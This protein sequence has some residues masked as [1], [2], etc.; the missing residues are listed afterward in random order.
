VVTQVSNL[1]AK[2]PLNTG[3]LYSLWAGA[4]DLFVQLGL[5]AAGAATPAQV[6]A[7]LATAATQLVQQ[8]GRLN[9]AGARYIIVWNL[10]DVGKTPFGVGSGQSAAIT[11]LSSFFNST[12]SAGLDALHIDVIRLNDFALLNEAIANPAAFG[13]TNVTTPAC[14][15]SSSLLCTSSTL[16]AFQRRADLSVRRQR[17]SDD[18]GASDPCR[19]RRVGDRSAGKDRPARRSA[20]A[21]RAGDVPRAR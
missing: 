3:A 13:L 5:A 18:G 12:L 6:Q 4:N 15:T 8:V 10:P 2:G 16:V 7:N 9:A 11:Q 19:L 21:G 1:L 20:F 14:T 17:S